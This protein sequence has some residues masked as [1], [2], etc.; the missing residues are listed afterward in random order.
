MFVF[1]VFPSKFH[2]KCNSNFYQRHQWLLESLFSVTIKILNEFFY[3]HKIFDSVHASYAYLCTLF[4]QK[5]L[6]I[7]HVSNKMF[8]PG[9]RKSNLKQNTAINT[10]KVRQYYETQKRFRYF[11]ENIFSSLLQKIYFSLL[12]ASCFIYFLHCT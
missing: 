1:R 10:I 7:G 12:K 2:P 5:P 9:C 4:L 6:K 8:Q 11:R 3:T